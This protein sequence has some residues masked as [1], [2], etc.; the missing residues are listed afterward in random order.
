MSL[1]APHEPL[2]LGIDA[3]G[4]HTRALLARLNGEILGAGEAGPANYQSTG[5]AAAFEALNQVVAQALSNA[6]QASVDQIQLACLGAAGMDRPED[7]A[8]FQGWAATALPNAR[9]RLVN[10]A[11]IALAA[12]TP[13]VWGLVIICGTGSI[14]YGRTP[15]GEVARAGGW[16][17]LLG[18]E[19]SGYDIG[20][21]A[22]RAVLRASD[23]RAA[24]TRLRDVILSAWQLAQPQDLVRKV[25]AGLP[26]SDFARLARLVED[27]A[28]SGDEVATGIM[29]RAGAELAE[30]AVA[31]T[32]R[33]GFIGPV[34]T[35]LTGGVMVRGRMVREALLASA[36][37]SGL[38]LE[39]VTPVS[40]PVR[41]A[42]RLALTS[43]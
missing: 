34:P 38:T 10:D 1:P 19:G 43:V 21:Q 32:R 24:P 42:L 33:L 35:A 9:V 7:M 6:G 17:Y 4:S 28:A 36:Q 23:G 16:G 12:G 30:A 41:G 25:Y 20:L 14:A 13:E 3:G 8:V 27:C 5:Q 31:V 15:Q 18:D 39:P 22:L 40:E 2:A 37:A 26:R 11:L 29:L